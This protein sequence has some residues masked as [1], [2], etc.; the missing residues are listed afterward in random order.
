MFL[1]NKLY[2][3]E[4]KT[5]QIKTIYENNEKNYANLMLAGVFVVYAGNG[6]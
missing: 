2:L 6:R 5:K 3:C 4:N 1:K